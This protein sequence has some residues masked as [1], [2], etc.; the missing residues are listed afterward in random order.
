MKPTPFLRFLLVL[1]LPLALSCTP[2]SPTSSPDTGQIRHDIMQVLNAQTQ[3]WN[4]GNIPG[5]MQGY[6]QSDSLVF[7]GKKGLTYGWQPTLDNYQ[8]SYPDAAAMGQLSFTSLKITPLEAGTAQV[9]GGWH[10]ARPQAGDLQ[11]HFLLIMRK[12]DGK[13]VVVADHSS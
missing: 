3:A 6:W 9:V 8:K 10:L 2:S 13:W 1:P 12:I 4:Q 7:I 11:G 5:Y